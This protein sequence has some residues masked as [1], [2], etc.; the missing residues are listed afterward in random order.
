MKDS[1]NLFFSM[2]NADD[3]NLYGDILY[4]NRTDDTMHSLTDYLIHKKLVSIDEYMFEC[5]LK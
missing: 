1:K 2:S 4:F 3:F 5:N